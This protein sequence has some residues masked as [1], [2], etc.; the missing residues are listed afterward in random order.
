MKTNIETKVENI[1]PATAKAYLEVAAPNR[2]LNQRAV[3]RYTHAMKSG[4][5]RLTHQ[6]IA[7]DE[8]GKMIDGQHRLTAII[9]SG[10]TV[11][12]NVSRYSAN[13]PMAVLDSGASRTVSDRVQISGIIGKHTREVVATLNAM[14][15]AETG[16]SSRET[17]Q[18]HEIESLYGQESGAI[19]FVFTAFGAKHSTQWNSIVR[20]GFAYCSA[21]APIE[22]AQ[23]ATM[24]R[25]KVGYKKGSAAHA[26]VVA[27]TEG[28]LQ[29]RSH[30][31]R[32]DTMAK[33]LWLIR[34]HIE[35]KNVERTRA[36]AS[37]FNW[38]ARQRQTKNRLLAPLLK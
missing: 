1:G 22:T 17:L 8:N 35:G 12:M 27:L 20:A 24:I 33:V 18:P 14:L 16:N 4:G 34:Q 38:A 23:L 32:A 30:S 15:L 37:V 28:K 36:T 25:E 3:A 26:F 31:E 13:A 5:W 10:K 21:F 6:G 11:Q 7:F 19:D 9:A 29:S 2:K